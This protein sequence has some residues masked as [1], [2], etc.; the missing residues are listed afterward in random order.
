[1]AITRRAAEWGIRRTRCF[2][3]GRMSN[4]ADGVVN[5]ARIPGGS[6]MNFGS[7]LGG[8]DARQA[9]AGGGPKSRTIVNHR[10]EIMRNVVYSRWAI[11]LI[12]GLR[13]ILI[14]MRIHLW[15]SDHAPPSTANHNRLIRNAESLRAPWR[16]GTQHRAVSGERN[17]EMN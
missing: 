4:K 8:G 17:F 14:H 12:R 2:N 5:T 15:M 3:S 16:V 13:R 11:N 9:E 7:F 10:P 1:M 6:G